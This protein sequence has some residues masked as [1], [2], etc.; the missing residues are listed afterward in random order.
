MLHL[1]ECTCYKDNIKVLKRNFQMLFKQYND[2]HA[3]TTLHFILFTFLKIN[4]NVSFLLCMRRCLFMVSS[5]SDATL[6]LL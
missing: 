6:C 1:P 3:S 2:K 5:S 4:F